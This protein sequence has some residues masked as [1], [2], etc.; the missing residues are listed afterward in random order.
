MPSALRCW[1][2]EQPAPSA[3]ARTNR[4]EPLRLVSN[5]VSNGLQRPQMT[6]SANRRFWN[7]NEFQKGGQGGSRTHGTDEG[8]LDF[9][10]SAL[11]HSATCPNMLTDNYLISSAQE[12]IYT[13]YTPTL[14][15]SR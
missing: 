10:S 2:R 7:H 9:E 14:Y 8:T 6:P 1:P 4:P 12:E 5:L 15:R 3:G 11:N 13:L